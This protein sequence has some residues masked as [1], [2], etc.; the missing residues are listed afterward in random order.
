M[1]LLQQGVVAVAEEGGRKLMH[2]LINLK[3]KLFPEFFVIQTQF[4]NSNRQKADFG[5]FIVID[6]FDQI[7]DEVLN[8]G[9]SVPIITYSRLTIG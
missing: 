9:M 6:I 8:P 2:A 1:R 7:V 5:D 4:E 3:F